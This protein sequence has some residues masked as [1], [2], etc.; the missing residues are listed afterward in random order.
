MPQSRHNNSENRLSVMSINELYFNRV[1]NKGPGP[2]MAWW[3][4]VR[5][6]QENVSDNNYHSVPGQLFEACDIKI[7]LQNSA[8]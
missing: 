2:I 7:H 5:T 3:D 4:L 6:L 1:L 8:R